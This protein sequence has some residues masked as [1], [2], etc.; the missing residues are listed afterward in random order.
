MSDFIY[1]PQ[2][3]G[4]T[5]KYELSQTEALSKPSQKTF[6][7][8]VAYS[9][10]HV[11]ANPFGTTDPVR[12]PVIDWEQTMQYRHYLWSLGLSVAEAMDTAQRGMGLQWQHA[13]EL[14]TRSVKEA[15]SVNGNIA[16][17]AGTDHLEP[18]PSVTLED[19]VNAY[20][21]QVA[22]VEGAGSKVI[23]M[24][25]RALASCAKS[26]EDYEYVYGKI[27]DQVS[28]PITLH[29]LGDMFDPNLA[30]Y[31]GYDDLDEAMD[32]CLR[33]IHTH[34][35]KIEG[36][37][38]SLLDDQKEIKMRR[39]LP[40]SVRMYTGDD[41]NYP[42][43]IEGDEQGYSHALLGIFD[44]IAPAA[45]SA[46]HDLDEGKIGTFRETLDRTVPLAR[47]IFQKPTYAY[48]T[49]VVFLAYLNGHQSHFRMI[50][51]TESARSILHLTELFELADQAHVLTNPERAI[52]RMKP[53]LQLA[54]IEQ[55]E[56]V[57]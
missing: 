25:S 45:A 4:S 50:A 2:Q 30:G 24:A 42:S 51:G 43:L 27:L 13:K 37:K 29:W 28:Q 57:K 1:L 26:P 21:E 7:S 9:A 41:F 49:G 34:A 46:L 35:N 33:I 54:G 31:W 22:H 15:K 38:I 20:E 53:I 3:D 23:L 5:Y 48:K 55:T 16:S 18:D 32:V 56:A 6:D 40:E 44:A 39:R 36:I 47:H 14:I 52:E 19:V 12:Q 11:V 8:R 17:G 10:A